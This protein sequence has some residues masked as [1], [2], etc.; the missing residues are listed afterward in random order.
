MT[1]VTIKRYEAADGGVFEEGV[2]YPDGRERSISYEALFDG[3][4]LK[5]VTLTGL[6]ITSSHRPL[7]EYS[8]TPTAGI[9]RQI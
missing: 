6:V 4:T 7:V 5:W 9:G 3:I 1:I 2:Y 8:Y